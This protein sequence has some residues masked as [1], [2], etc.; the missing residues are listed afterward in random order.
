MD[1]VVC[2]AVKKAILKD[3]ERWVIRKEHWVLRV[4]WEGSDYT[5]ESMAYL[6]SMILEYFQDRLRSTP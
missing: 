2:T 4:Y 3:C 5:S 6:L 1:A